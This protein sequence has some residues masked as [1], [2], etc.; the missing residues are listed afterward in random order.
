MGQIGHEREGVIEFF[1]DD[2]SE[3]LP[4]ELLDNVL[5]A[6]QKMIHLQTRGVGAVKGIFDPVH[7][8]FIIASTLA[9]DP[10]EKQTLLEL[11][12]TTERIR[13]LDTALMHMVSQLEKQ[14]ALERRAGTNGHGKHDE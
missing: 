11:T 13:K 9:L 2:S 1:D 10:P 3:D 7:F 14:A 4:D 8:S 12:S 6:Y 5:N